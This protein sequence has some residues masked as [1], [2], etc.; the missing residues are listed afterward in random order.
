ME[1]RTQS[2]GRVCTNVR[3][4]T[5]PREF[6]RLM[7]KK[8]S[9]APRNYTSR[10]TVSHS[11]L[12]ETQLN[13]ERDRINMRRLTAGLVIFALVVKVGRHPV[14][15]SFEGPYPGDPLVTIAPQAVGRYRQDRRALPEPNSLTESVSG[16]RLPQHR[17]A[18]LLPSLGRQ[19]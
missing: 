4:P 6:V 15:P 17:V 3:M 5:M 18:E 11:R 2:A 1:F 8:S 7:T 16:F 10:L 13:Q 19:S 12:L 14:H 9:A